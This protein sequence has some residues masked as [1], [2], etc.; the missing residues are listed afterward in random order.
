VPLISQMCEKPKRLLYA[1]TYARP[2]A[3]LI[4]DQQA[5]WR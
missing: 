2:V 4:C 3:S 5:N 1:K